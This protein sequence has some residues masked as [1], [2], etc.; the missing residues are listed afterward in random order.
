MTIGILPK[1]NAYSL[2]PIWFDSLR[3]RLLLSQINIKKL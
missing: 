3:C 1:N 2:L